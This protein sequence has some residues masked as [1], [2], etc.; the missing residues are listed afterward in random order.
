MKC[1]RHLK[2]KFPSLSACSAMLFCFAWLT[3]AAGTW[4]VEHS[5][6]PFAM[7]T[8]QRAKTPKR[9][10]DHRN[11]QLFG[12]GFLPERSFNS[13]TNYLARVPKRGPVVDRAFRELIAR[14]EAHGSV[15]V[16]VGLNVPFEIETKSTNSPTLRKQRQL[17]R[18]SQD[19]LL[20]RLPGPT[21]SSVTKFSFI[22]AM[23]LEVNALSLRSLEAS[24]DVLT[25]E[26][27]LI[28]K[29]TLAESVPL[30]GTPDAWASGFTASG[31]VVAILDTGVD[32]SHPF[33]SGKVISE[34]CYSSNLCPPGYISG[35]TDSGSGVNCTAPGCKHGTHVAGIAAG[36]SGGSSGVARDATIIAIQV[37]SQNEN[38]DIG[39][40]NTNTISGLQRVFELSET[41]S[42]AA[43]NLSIGTEDIKY[44][45]DCDYV[46]PMFKLAIDVLRQRGIAT[47][48][49]SGNDSFADGLAF[50]ACIS[51]GIRVGST[52]DGSSHVS[53]GIVNCETVPTTADAV[54]FF[55][56]SDKTLNLLAPGRW[57]YSSVPGPSFENMS[58][59]SQAAPHVTG[60]FAVLKSRLPTASV[61]EILTALTITG[62][63]I[64][65][66]RNNVTKPRIRIDAA[67]SALE[68]CDFRIRQQA[69]G[70]SVEST[71]RANPIQILGTNLSGAFES[72]DVKYEGSCNIN[73]P[74]YY[75]LVLQEFADGSYSF[76]SDSREFGSVTAKRSSS[77]GVQVDT[78]TASDFSST[79]SFDPSK[80]YAFMLYQLDASPI[81][82]EQ[83]TYL[84][85]CYDTREE[86]GPTLDCQQSTNL[87][88][89][90][91]DLRVRS[92]FS[93]CSP[94]ISSVRPSSLGIG[95]KVIINGSSFGSQQVSSFVKFGSTTALIDSWS[96]VQIVALAPSGLEGTVPVTVTTG[97]GT[98]N[99]R[100]FTYFP[101][102]AQCNSIVRQQSGLDFCG[103]GLDVPNDCGSNAGGV[104]HLHKHAQV[105]TSSATVLPGNLALK[106]GGFYD[107]PANF[108]N[109]RAY[110][111]DVSDPDNAHNDNLVASSDVLNMATSQ[112]GQNILLSFTG[113]QNPLLQGHT[114][115]LIVEASAG[116]SS[117]GTFGLKGSNDGNNNP[118]GSAYTWVENTFKTGVEVSGNNS[119]VP[120]YFYFVLCGS[121]SQPSFS[122]GDGTVIEGHSGTTN[123]AF[124]VT[125]TGSSSQT[126]TVD[127]A[128]LNGTATAAIDYVA[129]SGQLNFAPNETSKQVTVQVSADTVHEPD[130]N[131]FVN[132]SAS[133][134]AII[135]D[136]QGEGTIVNDDAQPSLSIS[137]VSVVEGN[138]GTSDAAFMVTLSAASHQT[139]TVNYATADGT[140]AAGSDYQST[141]GLLTFAPGE[142]SKP[143]TTVIYGDPA[144]EPDEAFY[145]NLSGATNVV[146]ADVQAV[147]SITNDDAMPAFSIDDMEL[148][149]G[150]SGTTTILFNATLSHPSSQMVTV[151]FATAQGTALAGSDY[152]HASGSLTFN[153]G[154]ISKS[155]TVL[156][157]G[158][159]ANEQNETFVVNLSAATSS[160]IANYQGV[161]TILNDDG[162]P[163]L[164]INDL[165]LVEGNT[166]AASAS[167]TVALSPAS[168][169]TV[170][171][172]YGTVNGTAT[173]GDDY[174]NAS[175]SLTFNPGDTSK[176]ITILINGDTVLEFDET[177]VVSLSHPSN[178]LITDAQGQGT[179]L[180]DDAEP[181]PTPTPVPTPT[182]TPV[183]TPTPTPPGYTPAGSNVTVQGTGV[184]VTFSQ[185]NTP[186]STTINSLDP[187]NTGVT[188]DGYLI[189]GSSVAFEIATTAIYTAPIDLCFALPTGTDALIFNTLA[190]L[191]NEAGML[192]DRTSSRNFDTK[193]ICGRVNSLSPFVIASKL[194]VQY[195]TSAV[196]VH[197][198]LDASTKVDLTV[199]RSGDASSPATVNYASSDGTASE[200]SDYL[201]AVGTLRFAACET[202]RTLS[203]FI[204]DD[205]FDEGDETFSVVLSNPVGLVLGSQV[206]V[207]VTIIS[208]DNV[209]SGNP[210]RN[211][212]FNS[213]FFVR[214]KYLDF[215]NRAADE[216]G[217]NF[218]R[219]QI[220]ECELRPLSER[221]ACREIRRINV[222]A[223]FFVSIEFQE[224]GYLVYK[225]YQAA[226]NTGEFLRLRDFLPDQQEIGRGVIFGQPGADA[227]LEANKVAFFNDFVQRPAFVASGAFPITMSAAAFVDKLNANTFDPRNPGAGSLTSS[228]RSSLISQLTPNPSSPILRAQVLRSIS[229]NSV[230]TSRQFNK[231]FVLMQYFGYLRRNPN[232]PP[233][234]GLDFAGYNF[235]LSKLN[236][237]NGNYITAEMVNAFISASEYQQRFGP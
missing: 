217:L 169:Q 187:V 18:E 32:K 229:E 126:S 173:G 100:D 197:E 204:V 59:T 66:S 137:D 136:A 118:G 15:R 67:I 215:L 68:V 84:E 207:T 108:V 33:L 185:V 80:H 209:N 219:N 198:T 30:I 40:P 129:H 98:S 82:T 237:F 146:L 81:G 103:E 214:Q 4:P 190:V 180:N 160:T 168:G 88:D 134:N 14:A 45:E 140:A 25:I 211:A 182:P 109:I 43:V 162:I 203:V 153:P 189:D 63:S 123:L 46:Y 133:T 177:Y 175:G 90:Y 227:Q 26:E 122:I 154:E 230:F 127:F 213:D 157:H 167:F 192:I 110:L 39:A 119:F 172:S 55:S 91:F 225:A 27:D 49:S 124:T 86:F 220:D 7:D 60:A 9:K 171:V 47:V 12:L 6:I 22:P 159:I 164:S 149:E 48:I 71:R 93:S 151:N 208:N 101:S 102:A 21:P 199:T 194:A 116:G 144:H 152:Q 75:R 83:E 216:P 72:L 8:Q 76:A 222:S 10:P 141:L 142:M 200:R 132:L 3:L 121:A 195:T 85:G 196:T 61:D 58:G 114:Y 156:V 51:S 125:R 166:G 186:G 193:E 17:I 23:G 191:H 155:L 233:E 29:P 1:A 143:I 56:N 42:I 202:A 2:A 165:S 54:S 112:Q 31:Q 73:N 210:V 38:G 176:T 44:T 50:P 89:L 128:T 36:K 147:G 77:C 226:F 20:S 111:H 184:G 99:S 224:T 120:R 94:A 223:A 37:F 148:N 139:V 95:G 28:V 35:S 104:N 145:I 183:P 135:G 41:N 92:H 163:G 97:E 64:T 5:S 62:R 87:K 69:D 179:I 34:A 181:T 236:Q 19:Y 174:Q 115:T 158:D 150:N 188:P 13:I 70:S 79:V 201:A 74:H 107:N 117:V 78:W 65:D 161:G 57:L 235:W 234:L 24:S 53:C 113:A 11:S 16:I 205:R 130:E 178:G 206:S 170:T 106:I 218:W 52:D 228:Q 105:F 131:F 212:T 221:Q 231:A 232:D 96:N 138:S